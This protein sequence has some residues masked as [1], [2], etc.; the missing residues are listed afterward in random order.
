MIVDRPSMQFQPKRFHLPRPGWNFH[1]LCPLLLLL[2]YLPIYLT[3]G[4]NGTYSSLY[5]N[6]G[7]HREGLQ[8]GH[9]WSL[10]THALLHGSWTHWLTNSFFL[11]YFG[12]RIHAIFGEKEVWRTALVTTLIGGISHLVVQGHNPLVGA[13]GAAFGLFIALTTVSPESKMFPLPIRARNLRNGFLLASVLFLLMI[14]PLEIPV[15][16]RMGQLIIQWGGQHLFNIGHAYHLGGALAGMLAMRKY[17]RK[18]ITL[19][20]LRRERAEREEEGNEA[21]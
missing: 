10:F 13:S 7:L 11:Y 17:L 12:G 5:L 4:P 21:A 18:P 9:I 14:P 16:S 15:F 6:L 1:T 3:G 20:Q 2:L 19:A 8:Q